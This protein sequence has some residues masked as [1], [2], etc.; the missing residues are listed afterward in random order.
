MKNRILSSILLAVLIVCIPLGALHFSG[1]PEIIPLP[2]G[3]PDNRK[4]PA[5]SSQTAST[6]DATLQTGQPETDIPAASESES[7]APTVNQTNTLASPA[8]F[9]ILNESTGRVMEVETKDFVRGA[10]AAEMPPN[11]HPEALKAQAVAAHSYAV[12][13]TLQ[14]E[15]RPVETLK[16]ATLTAD[17]ENWKGYTTEKIFRARYGSL[18]DEYWNDICQAAD[19]VS[20]Y[21]LSYD[22]EPAAA[23][24]HSMSSGITEDA[25]NVWEAS[26]PYLIPVDSPGDPLA[27]DY[28]TSVTVAEKRMRE[29]LETACPGV[30][31]PDD[32]AEWMTVSDR[33]E[34][35]YALNIQA[36]DS[37]LAGT[38]LRTLLGL[39]SAN[40]DIVYDGTAFVF[41]VRGYGH[42]VGLSQYGADYLARQ[43]M[44]FE[45]ILAHYYPGTALAA[46]VAQ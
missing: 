14:R 26:V 20:G 17:P 19:A 2:V 31:L 15:Q 39:R 45:E 10:L 22:G 16:G 5:Q 46:A 36:G 21:L 6:E 41:T 34:G 11:F 18:S 33:S 37:A 35:G 30:S 32:P 7:A 29:L 13:L 44:D 24:Y 23:A 43:G 25:A 1:Q 9:R 38:E 12:W 42:G 8:R 40:F 4:P 28:E 3:S 27:P